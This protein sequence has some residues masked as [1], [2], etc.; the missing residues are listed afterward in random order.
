MDQER[1]AV[2]QLAIATAVRWSV[3]TSSQ[4]A[5]SLLRG[6]SMGNPFPWI[7]GP[8][9]GRLT[10][11]GRAHQSSSGIRCLDQATCIQSSPRADVK[12]VTLTWR[13]CT[14]G[15]HPHASCQEPGGLSRL[16]DPA[17]PSKEIQEDCCP[18]PFAGFPSRGN[19]RWRLQMNTQ[20]SD[21][22][23]LFTQEMRCSERGAGGFS[24]IR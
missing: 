11:L 9:C 22:N 16:A 12:S 24:S 23:A 10:S 3:Q 7:G 14:S 19:Y 6:W 20:D 2:Q 21:E 5:T 8:P 15:R 13:A 17:H 4:P 1:Q 18:A